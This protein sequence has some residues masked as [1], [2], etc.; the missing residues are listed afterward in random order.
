VFCYDE[1]I[2]NGEGK[3]KKSSLL[4]L[5]LVVLSVLSYSQTIT[6]EKPETGDE[7]EKQRTYGIVWK[8][9]GTLP[10]WVKI[11]LRNKASTRTLHVISSKTENDGLYA[12]KVP[13]SVA[14]GDYVIRVKASG[15]A[16]WGDSDVFKIIPWKT[17]HPVD[18]RSLAELRKI[19]V[20]SPKE[21]ENWHS[22]KTYTIKWET[23]LEGP[24]KLELS[25]EPRRDR[26]V[27]EIGIYQSNIVPVDGR[28]T[29]QWTIPRGIV[30]DP[31]DWDYFYVRVA[32]PDD[33]FEG[34]SEIF[35][36][37]DR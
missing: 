22:E 3:M 7:W 28:H 15:V 33:K 14:E 10:D 18:E 9:S 11:W 1:D 8:S 2:E 37:Y 5:F 26:V 17:R 25:Y 30:F 23:R 21:G 29:Y 16:V 24:F 35:Y 32:T 31:Q 12:W 13:A 20:T 27:A 34:F 4:F 36:I 19:R 6:V